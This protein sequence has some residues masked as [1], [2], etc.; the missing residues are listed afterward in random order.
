MNR[1]DNRKRTNSAQQSCRDA[2]TREMINKR[3]PSPES[4][5]TA[6][7]PRRAE[8]NPDPKAPLMFTHIL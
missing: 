2:L 6:A 5:L 8:D 7:G 4:L 3:T 1:G